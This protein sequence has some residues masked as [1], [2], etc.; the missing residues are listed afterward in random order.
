MGY[1]EAADKQDMIDLIRAAVDRGI[2]FFDTAE[3]YGPFR[4]E[5]VVGEALAPF[6]GTV[7]IAT[8]FGWDIDPATGINRGGVNTGPAQIRRAVEGALRRLR[9][10]CVDL[11]YQHRVDPEVPMEE[12]AGTVRGRSPKAR[13]GISASPKPDRS[14]SAGR[15]RCIPSA[16]CKAS[17]P[18]GHVIPKR[19]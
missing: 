3:S 5:E 6:Q 1:G 15:M 16:L 19:R 8:K 4:N 14:R 9:V 7:V 10:E 12:V 13:R 2:T 11:L 18:S 17:T